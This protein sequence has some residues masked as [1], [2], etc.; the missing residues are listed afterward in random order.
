MTE[1]ELI[2]RLQSIVNDGRTSLTQTGLI[3]IGDDAAVLAVAAD[4]QLLVTTD[5]LVSGVHFPAN[6]LAADIGHKA[7]AVN[8]SDLAAMGADPAWF[9]L[10][11]TL[12]QADTAWLDEFAGGVANLARPCGIE[13]AGG[14]TTSGPL[15]ITITA[16]GLVKRGKAILR[17]G[18]SAGGR[19]SPACAWRSRDSD[20]WD[21]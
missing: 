4:Q 10:A 7:L 14:D 11:L 6:S 12:P 15:S 9:F 2:A 18:A 19:T 3:G 20:R 21:R 17:S 1:F 8:L 16:L 13:L 5:T